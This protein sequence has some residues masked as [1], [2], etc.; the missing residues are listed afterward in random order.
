MG[1]HRS[2][3]LLG[4]QPPPHW[5]GFNL[6]S[7]HTSWLPL[8]WYYACYLHGLGAGWWWCI[9]G[10]G[11][12]REWCCGGDPSRGGRGLGWGVRK[13]LVPSCLP[14]APRPFCRER[15]DWVLPLTLLLVIP[16]TPLPCP[17][18]G[19]PSHPGVLLCVPGETAMIAMRGG[20]MI[21]MAFWSYYCS[22]PAAVVLGGAIGG[23]GGAAEAPVARLSGAGPG[24][25]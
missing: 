5:V 25:Y 4:G 12:A 22:L 1:P 23:G 8:C 13:I 17:S 24:C 14:C 2:A 16:L 20:A 7:P 18:P 9:W 3:A 15:R 11:G 10:C 19:A 6:W 21:M